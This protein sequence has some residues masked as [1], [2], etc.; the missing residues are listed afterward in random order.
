[1]KK[2]NLNLSSAFL[3]LLLLLFIASIILY[4]FNNSVVESFNKFLN[5]GFNSKILDIFLIGFCITKYQEYLNKKTK[6]KNLQ[7]TIDDLKKINTLEAKHQIAG[8]IRRMN[9]DGK[10]NIDFDGIFLSH[11]N[12]KEFDIFNISGSTFC[13]E[14]L[15][16]GSEKIC[17]ISN[18]DFSNINMDSTKFLGFTPLRNL[19]KEKAS[20]CINN[21]CFMGASIKDASFIGV[22]INYN[23]FPL[24]SLYEEIDNG[25]YAQTNYSEFHETDIKNTKFINTNFKNVDFR[26][27]INLQKAIFEECLGLE[28]CSFDF[29]DKQYLIN[30]GILKT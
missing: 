14:S 10:F 27:V 11:F 1:M 22:D 28:T 5:W 20:V 15:E 25:I 12:F 3:I 16:I 21:C 7:N 17:S 24:D 13:G 19:T 23:T 8:C 4:F 6:I 18:V 2:N 9:E 30:L 26:G 29:E